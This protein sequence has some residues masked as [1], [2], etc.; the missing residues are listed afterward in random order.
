MNL[1][2]LEKILKNIYQI[3]RMNIALFDNKFHTVLS[4]GHTA[5]CYCNVLHRNAECLEACHNSD[6]SYLLQVR[7]NP[8]L[9]TYTCPFGFYTALAPILNDGELI[10]CLVL[11]PGLEDKEGQ[12]EIPVQKARAIAPEIDSERIKASISKIPHYPK[13]VLDSYAEILLMA[14]KHIEHSRLI[15]DTRQNIAYLVRSYIDK[16]LHH[17]ITLTDLS[18][19]L[20]C[21]KVTITEHF[22][23]EYGISVVQYTL[24]K[25]MELAK[26]LLEEGADSINSVAFACGFSDI[27]YFSRTFKKFYGISPSKWPQNVS[28]ENEQ[29]LR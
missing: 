28:K 10:A 15:D 7:E 5:N 24:K 27:E 26:E 29:S 17:K 6:F 2:E 18:W 3:S 16:N 8:R 13:K 21:S 19:H 12:D 20:H 22:K 25:R 1:R 11:A 9:I 23:R 4:I 14:A